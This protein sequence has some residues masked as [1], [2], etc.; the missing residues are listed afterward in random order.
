MQLFEAIIFGIVQGITEFLPVSSTAHIVITE[1][2]FGYNFPGLAFEIFLHLASVLAVIL[3]F[4]RE[5]WAV[6]SGFF[7]YFRD[8]SAEN[9]V[10]FFFGLYIVVASAITGGLGLLLHGLVE[11]VMKTPPFIAGALVLTGTALIFIERFRDYGSRT[12]KK[13]TFWDS[14]LV[15][16]GQS[17]AILP[18]ISRSGSTLVVALWIGLERETAVRY[19]FL[20]AIPIILGSS[21]LAVRD[22]SGAAW[23]SIG[24]TSL[25]IS[26]AASFIFSLIGIVWLIDFLK[27]G[28]LLYFAI[29][30][31]IVALLVFL[32][33]QEVP[34]QAVVG[35]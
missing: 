12:E 1:L 6:I 19:S 18:G 20:L 3:Y 21:I 33:V 2:L 14:I 32:F 10:H 4:R 27:R 17:I 9:R 8:K 30:C 24:L 28:R 23:S 25:V 11:D 22:V 34:Q 29:Y 7:L 35:L 31:Y 5:L 16:L 13:M 26:F 15:G